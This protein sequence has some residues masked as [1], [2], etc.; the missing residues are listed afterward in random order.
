[1]QT[2]NILDD[3]FSEFN[4]LR[5]FDSNHFENTKHGLA[6]LEQLQTSL[7]FEKILN[8]FAME[9]SKYI[10]FSGLIFKNRKIIRSIRGSRAG[11]IEKK[12]ELKIAG[13]FVGVLTY[14]F[15]SP[16]SSTNNKILNELH[17][18]LIYPLKNAIQYHNAIQLAM[19]DSLTGLG[20]RR[21]FDE[22]LKRAMHQACRQN[23]EVGLI[24]CDL[25]KFKNI[26]DTFGH[27]EG[28]KVLVHFAKALRKSIRDCD[29][30]FRFGGDE[31]SIIVESASKQSLAIIDNRINQAISQDNLLTHYNVS[32][33]LGM[34]F[35]QKNDN[36]QSFFERTDKLLYQNKLAP[37]RQLSLA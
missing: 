25:D 2:L 4:A 19:Q 28:D 16:I 31:F 18:Y 22:Q 17:Q 30:I 37:V 36:E 20:N 1:M 5:V 9:A 21:C 10:E 15:N 24:L 34:T 12:Y 8:M 32:S 23:S 11:K 3:H 6:L 13:E 7:D 29:S 35:M 33:S 14:T 27:Q 26:N